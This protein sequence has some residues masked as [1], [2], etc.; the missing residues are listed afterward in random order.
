LGVAV[1]PE[2]IQVIARAARATPRVAN[3][4]LRRAR[5]YAEVHGA[6]TL[7]EAAARSALNLLEIDERG[8]EPQDR[9]LLEIAIRKFSGGP[10]GLQ[11]LAAAM[12]EE[13]GA[14]EEIY[15]PYLMS[16]GFLQRTPAGRVVLPAAYEH[17]GIQR[18]GEFL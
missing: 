16:L 15:E 12:N 18:P 3:R 7:D 2:A 17:L 4:L 8:L 1:S 6:R 11:T 9:R 14:I 5:D 10:V 13:K